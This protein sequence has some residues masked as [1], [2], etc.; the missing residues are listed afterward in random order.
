MQCCTLDLRCKADSKKKSG[1][2]VIQSLRVLVH[3]KPICIGRVPDCAQPT[4]SPARHFVVQLNSYRFSL[5]LISRSIKGWWSIEFSHH[6]SLSALTTKRTKDEIYRKPIKYI[7]CNNLLN[8]LVQ[9]YF[10]LFIL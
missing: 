6:P 10:M 1:F 8:V 4:H 2:R 3:R 5:L 7:P 9:N